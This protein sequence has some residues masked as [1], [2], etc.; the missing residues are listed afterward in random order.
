MYAIKKIMFY[1]QQMHVHAVK[2]LMLMYYNVNKISNLNI[3]AIIMSQVS[4]IPVYSI[5]SKE[6]LPYYLT[7]YIPVIFITAFVASLCKLYISFL[8]KLSRRLTERNE[9]HIKYLVD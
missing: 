5:L 3:L 1:N 4:E 9:T 6:Y 2:L 7:R 8:I